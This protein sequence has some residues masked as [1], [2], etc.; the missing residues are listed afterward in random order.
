MRSFRFFPLVLSLAVIPAT[1]IAARTMSLQEDRPRRATDQAEIDENR[2][3]RERA[4]RR[5]RQE[6]R[7]QRWEKAARRSGDPCELGCGDYGGR[8]TREVPDSPLVAVLHGTKLD[9][10]VL[11]VRLRFHN[12]GSEPARLAIDP[13]SAYESFF[14]KVG[15][16]RLFILKDE[17]GELEA[18]AR[19]EVDL[20]PGTM[21]TW[22]AKF[23][24]PAPE[25]KAFDLEIPPIAPFRNV[26]LSDD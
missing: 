10:G 25:T 5:A 26:P 19:L 7:D 18:K 24:A 17:D 22:W 12:K 4:E 6:R 15:D 3:Q 23:P 14:V 2:E 21:E 16:E 20:K 1:P 13:S 8:Q 11:T 9:D